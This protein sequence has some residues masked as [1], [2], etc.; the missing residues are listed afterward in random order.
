MIKYAIV[1]LLFVFSPGLLAQDDMIRVVGDSLVGKTIN[2]ESIR[3]VH[4]NVIMTQGKVT[5]TCNKA[6]QYIAKNEA[7]L[8]G[9]VVVVQDSIIIKTDLGY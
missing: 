8:I 6:I 3:E 5:I 1:I 7:E 2:G 9:N 4:S